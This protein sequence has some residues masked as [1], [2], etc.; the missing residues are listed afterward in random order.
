MKKSAVISKKHII[1][2]VLVIALAAA[3]Y[4]NWQ[5]G[6][7]KVEN[8]EDNTSSYLGAAQYVSATISDQASASVNPYFEETRHTR[9]ESRNSKLEILKETVSNVK[10]TEEEIAAAKAEIE[11][12]SNDIESEA[13][14]ES[15]VKAK[16]FSDC[17]AILS[18]GTATIIVPSEGLLAS[19]TVQ[20]Q[21]IVSSQ[22]GYSLE[23]IKI[24]EIN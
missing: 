21:D 3:V 19:Q 22:T 17:A 16:G 14:I 13:N 9:E 12:I 20:I 1:L 8:T 11:Q 2:S 18:N 10:S 6:S 4:L 15:L 23:N 24:I 7:Q 5:F